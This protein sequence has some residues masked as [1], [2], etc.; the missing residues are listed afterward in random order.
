MSPRYF[1]FLAIFLL[2]PHP[3]YAHGSEVAL[4]ALA[5]IGA[6]FGVFVLIALAIAGM[7]MKNTRGPWLTR[8]QSLLAGAAA[9]PLLFGFQ[10]LTVQILA[11][12]ACH[13]NVC[14]LGGT[15]LLFDSMPAFFAVLCIIVVGFT[16]LF[17]RFCA[18]LDRK[19]DGTAAVRLRL[20]E[21]IV[22]AGL[23][24]IILYP[25]NRILS[26]VAA[27]PVPAYAKNIKPF[28]EEEIWNAYH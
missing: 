18:R 9:S 7:I 12:P 28:T 26:H 3:A 4:V 14:P 19:A 8:W 5:F 11:P 27:P 23:P 1:L 6:M 16:L 10:N 2:L 21:F 15:P 17:S 13:G 24:L 25:A 20:P 22:M